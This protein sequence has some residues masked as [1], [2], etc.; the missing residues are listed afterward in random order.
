MAS[1]STPEVIWYRES[2]GA[3]RLWAGPEVAQR[4]GVEVEARSNR[5]RS[6]RQS[7][8]KGLESRD[9]YRSP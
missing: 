6:V 3:G 2:R 4:P 7:R 9:G 1:K 5:T 8:G